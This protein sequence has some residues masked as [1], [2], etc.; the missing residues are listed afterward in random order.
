M[1]QVSE[2]VRGDAPGAMTVESRGFPRV[3]FV[4]TFAFNTMNGGG[5]TFSNLFRGWPKDRLATVHND[6][7]PTSDD[8]CNLYFRLGPDELRRWGPLEWL[9]PSHRAGGTGAAASDAAAPVSR[10]MLQRIRAQVFGSGVPETARLSPALEQFIAAFRPELIYTTLGGQGMVDLV[11]AIRARFPLPVVV[12]LMDDWRDTIYG[13]GWLSGWQRDRLNRKITKLMRVASA[14]MGI[15]TE[16]TERLA[17]DFG[18]PFS[19]FQNCVDAAR[20]SAFA[21]GDLT[22]GAQPR[23]VYAGS[24]LPFAQAEA[25]VEAATAVAALARQGVDIRFDIFAPP[26]AVAPYRDRLALG[27]AVRVLP[28]F[29]RWEDYYRNIVDADIL[30]LPVNF[31]AT[32]LR[33]IR[34]SMPTKIP[35]YLMSGTPVLVY[36]PEGV[37]QVDYARR[38]GWGHVVSQQGVASL[39]AGIREL[40]TDEAL[41]KRVTTRGRALAMERH[42]ATKVRAEF[43]DTLKAAAET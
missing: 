31:D 5:V 41:R 15:C 12:H 6:P 40:L 35:E 34:Y 16:M 17:R 25:V 38:E 43:Q 37:A 4:T 30:L 10:S 19:A 9:A 18:L 42:E 21:R 27:P 3:L 39:A 32:T 36:G 29:E 1:R 22:P 23:M 28:L 24:L 2:T 13:D 8:V 14:R 7:L 26:G 20:L 11:E 33:F